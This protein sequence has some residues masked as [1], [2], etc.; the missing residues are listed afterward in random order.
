MI[1]AVLKKCRHVHSGI[2]RFVP[3]TV[4]EKWLRVKGISSTPH[5]DAVAV[6]ICDRRHTLIGTSV[7]FFFCRTITIDKRDH[8]CSV[9]THSQMDTGASAEISNRKT[10]NEESILAVNIVN[11]SPIFQLNRTSVRPLSWRCTSSSKRIQAIVSRS[12]RH[13][14]LVLSDHCHG[15]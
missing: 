6:P 2:Q 5:I 7:K 8:V 4:M 13:Q 12:E 14:I 10:N 15:Y 3:A 9:K 1:L 11:S